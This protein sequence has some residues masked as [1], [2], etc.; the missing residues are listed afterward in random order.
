MN[1]TVVTTGQ[2]FA[3]I[4]AVACAIAYAELLHIEGKSAEVVLPGTLNNSITN[5]VKAWKLDYL[6]KPTHSDTEYVLVDISDPVHFATCTKHGTVT[7]VY[8]HHPG[9]ETYWQEKI[10]ANA[11]IK[12]IGAAATLIWEEWKKRGQSKNITQKSAQLLAV[13]ILSNTLNFGAIITDKRDHIAFD[14]LQA[15][16]PLTSEWIARYFIEQESAVMQDVEQAI[17][18]DT[19]VLTLSGCPFPVTVGQLELWDGRVFLNTNTEAIQSALE[20]FGHE[21]WIMSIPSLSEKKN[22]FYAKNE[23]LKLLFSQKIGATF[24]GNYATTPRLW[25]RKEIL[26]KFSK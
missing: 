8:D 3:D 24:D 21:H 22:H 2:A 17:K 19:K 7:E 11:H 1:P 6:T 5:S 15:R 18:S 9:F 12:P 26:K 14:E 20:S 4:D 10:G 23:D 16:F 25:L 13:A